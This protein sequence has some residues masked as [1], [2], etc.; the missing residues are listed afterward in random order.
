MN[1]TA[2]GCADSLPDEFANVA[3]VTFLADLCTRPG[4]IAEYTDDAERLVLVLH[5]DDYTLSSVQ[6]QI[7]A[8][9]I[10][11]LGIQLLDVAAA[12]GDA[13]RLDVMVAGALAR[14]EKYAGSKPEHA[15]PVFPAVVSRRELLTIPKPTYEAVPLVNHEV[16]AASDGCHACVAECPQDAYRW[17]EGRIRFDKDRCVPC[18]RCV[19]VCPTAAIGNPAVTPLQ[20]QAQIE[21]MVAAANE[22]IGVAFTCRQANRAAVAPGWY[23]VEVPC[24]GMVPGTWPLAALLLGAGAATAL[25]C[26]AVGCP[27]GHD[28]ITSEK[29]A[30][31]RKLA[32]ETGID[33]DRVPREGARIVTEPSPAL[34]LEDPFG[35]HG[36]AEV[37]AGL[38]MLAGTPAGLVLDHPGSPL[39]LVGV[40]AEACTMCL[41]CA[42]TCPTGAL[43][44]RYEGESLALFFAADSCTACGQCVASCPEI[45]RDAIRL[46]NGVATEALRSDPALLNE[47]DTVVCES[48]GKPFAAVPMMDRI[49]TLLGDDS[50]ATMDYLSRRCMDC[51]GAW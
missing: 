49:R 33:P 2:L 41:T 12:A 26:D 51:R 6:T 48:C 7:R 19:T 9:G 46:R 50:A 44:H 4:Q 22:P 3:R 20:M 43:S 28:A 39:G 14:V 32:Q 27:L 30:F 15:K 34:P 1:T 47:A 38:E 21:A 16:C 13:H 37:V 23:Q 42:Q 45:S 18:G 35:V 17:A 25:P 24:T 10:D 5:R 36:P 29:M 40:D 11:P 31:A 8:V